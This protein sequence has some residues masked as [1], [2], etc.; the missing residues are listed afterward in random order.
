MIG[1][2]ELCVD[3]F[4]LIDLQINNS[5]FVENPFINHGKYGQF[6][7]SFPVDISVIM[8]HMM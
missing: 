4:Y 2:F 1:I 8:S 6:Y 5:S 3:I 7:G